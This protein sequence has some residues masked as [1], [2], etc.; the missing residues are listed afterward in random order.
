VRTI[1]L[2]LLWH[3]AC[4]AATGCSKR[5]IGE[6]ASSSGNAAM[7][8]D[9]S[10]LSGLSWYYD[11]KLDP[12][13]AFEKDT[14]SQEF[15]PMVWG[16]SS[17]STL[18]S[19]T[20]LHD[21]TAILGFNEPNMASQSNLTPAEACYYWPNVTSFAARHNLR[22]GSPAA[23]SCNVGTVCT[24]TPIDWFDEF[25]ALPGCG[26]DTVDFIATHKYGCNDTALLEYVQE[27]SARY[28]KTVWLTEF[29]CSEAADT[30]QLAFQQSVIPSLDSLNESI[31]ERYAWFAARTSMAS[32]SLQVH[33][34][35]LQANES[36]L[37]TLGKYYVSS[38]AEE[39]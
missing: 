29:S 7:A 16:K 3:F 5:G 31:L 34:T 30:K 12:L 13:E 38:C 14:V 26:S 11:W 33:A 25:F 6:F 20:P 18:N 39:L 37:T 35:L 1:C 28:N 9:M 22:V 24:K 2:F 21:A 36:Q 27:L 8:G 15:V 4:T 10:L 19:F 23:N 17:I 32:S